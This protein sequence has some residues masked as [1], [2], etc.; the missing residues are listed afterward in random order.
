[1]EDFSGFFIPFL[2]G[3]WNLEDFERKDECPSLNI[4]EIIVS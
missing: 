3:A 4:S 2:K 1:M